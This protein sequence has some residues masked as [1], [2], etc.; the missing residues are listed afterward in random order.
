MSEL[1]PA[2]LKTRLADPEP[3]VLLDVRQDWETRLCRLEH[4]LRQDP[5]VLVLGQL[6]DE[7]AASA[8]LQAAEIGHLVIAAMSTVTAVDSIDRFVQLFP[9]PRQRQARAS[10]AA[11]LRGVVSQRLVPRAGG[12]GRV[13]AVEILVVN[14]RIRERIEEQRLAE[15]EEEMTVG[16]LEADPG[17]MRLAQ[18]A[19]R[20]LH[21]NG[22]G[23]HLDVDPL[24]DRD[25]FLTDSRHL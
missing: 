11:T 13:P 23:D 10:L 16:E 24:R 8:V 25:G 20:A 17:R 3:L 21:F 4:A 9:P 15:L 14:A 22:A 1:T 5:D 12:R 7:A 19:L 6:G 18:L 2:E